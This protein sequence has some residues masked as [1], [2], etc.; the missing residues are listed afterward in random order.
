[1]AGAPRELVVRDA[2][3]RH[4]A[5]RCRG[6]T[7]AARQHRDGMPLAAEGG[8]QPLGLRFDAPDLAV[9]RAEEGDP[10]RAVSAR[11]ASGQKLT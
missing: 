1:M 5:E 9:A 11:R 6:G 4:S 10:H 8:D 3:D 2:H 7:R